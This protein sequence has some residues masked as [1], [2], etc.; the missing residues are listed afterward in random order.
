MKQEIKTNVQVTITRNS[1]D[2]VSIQV[3]DDL[4]HAKFLD[5]R[6]TLEGF[7]LAVTGLGHVQA[8]AFIRG[9]ENVGR[10]KVSEDRVVVCP[11]NS[12]THNREELSNWIRENC[13]EE[14]W[15]IDAPLNSQGSVTRTGDGRA[16]LRYRVFRFEDVPGVSA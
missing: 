13:K 1:N 11:L 15:E 2:E 5:I 7:A 3:I 14:G 9:L 6:M 16:Q 8:P 10:K 4:S 12:Y